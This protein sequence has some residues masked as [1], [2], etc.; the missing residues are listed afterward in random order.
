MLPEINTVEPYSLKARANGRSISTFMNRCP[1]N[2]ARTSTHA[3][4]VPITTLIAETPSDAST[5]SLI[6]DHASGVVTSVQNPDQP[7]E[8][9]FHTIAASGSNTMMLM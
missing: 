6:V 5:V 1:K 4:N 7:D 8:C 3:I 2:L 9:A